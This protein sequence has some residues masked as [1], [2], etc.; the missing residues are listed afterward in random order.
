MPEMNR[1]SHGRSPYTWSKQLSRQAHTGPRMST[2]IAGSRTS[3]TAARDSRVAA[4]AAVGTMMSARTDPMGHQLP[5]Q[6]VPDAHW[7]RH[8]LAARFPRNHCTRALCS[9]TSAV[10]TGTSGTSVFNGP[11]PHPNRSQ[12]TTLPSKTSR[13][14]DGQPLNRGGPEAPH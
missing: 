7:A 2:K 1:P 14:P 10:S 13:H 6:T 3:A 4:A 9:V 12:K 5:L 11:G 8:A